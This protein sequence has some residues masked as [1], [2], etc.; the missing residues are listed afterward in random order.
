MHPTAT[1]EIVTTPDVWSILLQGLVSVLMAA[2]PVV[3]VWLRTRK[4]ALED[5]LARD[6]AAAE[7]AR[8]KAEKVEN[9]QRAVNQKLEEIATAALLSAKEATAMAALVTQNTDTQAKA[10]AAALAYDEHI[11]RTG[12][13]RDTQA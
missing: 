13:V 12:F 2:V 5:R 4:R 7:L 1:L 3:V 8:Q 11:A 6:E 9:A 10:D